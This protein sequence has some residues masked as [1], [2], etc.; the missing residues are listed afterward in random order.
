MKKISYLVC[1][2]CVVQL[3]MAQN[4]SCGN[5]LKAVE[6]E[7]R[8][9]IVALLEGVDP[10]CNIMGDGTPLVAAVRT[11]NMELVKL[12][13]NKGANV[14]YA[15]KGDGSPLIEAARTGQLEIVRYLLAQN[16]DVNVYL[17]S[18]ETPLIQAAWNG[19]LPVVRYLVDHGA[20]VNKTVRDKYGLV[21]EKR[22]AL[23]MAKREGHSAV[24]DYLITKGAK[25]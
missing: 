12:L 5:L 25:Q 10:N 22:N 7:N 21:S 14:N 1:V 9:A 23:R 20:E 2:L 8:S 6:D 4:Y 3:G 19:H 18:D 11:Q 16:A 24:V 13:V 15:I 17:E